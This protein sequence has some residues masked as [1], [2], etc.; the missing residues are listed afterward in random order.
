MKFGRHFISQQLQIWRWRKLG[1]YV[2]RTTNLSE[3][4]YK[5][6]TN[7]LFKII[8]IIIIAYKVLVGKPERKR[9]LGR[10][11]RIWEDSIKMELQEVERGHGLD[12]SGSGQGQVAGS[13]ECCNEPP[14]STKRGEFRED[15]LGSQEGLCSMDLLL[16]LLLLLL[17]IT[18]LW[19]S[20]L[21]WIRF[22]QPLCAT[23]TFN[24]VFSNLFLP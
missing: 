5:F 22:P 13:C 14:G 7:K 15:L 17:Y 1:G 12:W 19:S 8:I 9:P 6:N 4:E 21:R 23:Q 18:Y 3:P 11:G 16:L 20:G 10:Q 2:R 24:P